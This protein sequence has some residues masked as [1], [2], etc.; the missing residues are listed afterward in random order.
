VVLLLCLVGMEG[1]LSNGAIWRYGR[2]VPES[3]ILLAWSVTPHAAPSWRW[4]EDD[5]DDGESPNFRSI[6]IDAKS[7]KRATIAARAGGNL[8]PPQSSFI[9]LLILAWCNC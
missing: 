6:L 4:I 2:T 9:S 1:D 7:E 5:D 3:L 8:L